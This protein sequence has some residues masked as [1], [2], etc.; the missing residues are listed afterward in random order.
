MFEYKRRPKCKLAHYSSS[1]IIIIISNVP[2]IKQL[3]TG[4]QNINSQQFQYNRIMQSKPY[5]AKNCGSKFDHV[6]FD[7]QYKIIHAQT[8]S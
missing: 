4:K 2:K 7:Q 8:D 6:G 5:I 3:G 1:G